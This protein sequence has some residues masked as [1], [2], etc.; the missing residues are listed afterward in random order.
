MIV[1]E[2]PPNQGAK[3]RDRENS[4]RQTL[5]DAIGT[6]K[7]F[8]VERLTNL[9]VVQ[10]QGDSA[11]FH[12]ADV[13]NEADAIGFC[14][15]DNKGINLAVDL[16]VAKYFGSV[17]IGLIIGMARRCSEGGGKAALCCATDRTYDILRTMRL[18]ERWPYF[19]TREEVFAAWEN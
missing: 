2:Q 19:A 4:R 16:G 9:L 10:P 18:F 11:R 1:F 8:K 17:T 14:L 15:A 3:M 12:F 13:Q 6:H 5:L 7:V